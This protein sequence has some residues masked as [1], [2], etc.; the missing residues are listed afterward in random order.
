MPASRRLFSGGGGSV[1][2]YAERFIGPIDE[3]GDPLGGLS[4][5]ELGAELR[6][7]AFG[8]I[9]FAL[10]VEGGSVS[11]EPAPVFDEGFQIAAGVGL[12]YFSPVGPIRVD[13]GVPVNGREEDDAFQIYLSIGQAF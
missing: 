1:R 7:Q 11:E 8:D 10:F 2:G 9:G 3:N 4:V 13:V 5:V 6:A 12:R